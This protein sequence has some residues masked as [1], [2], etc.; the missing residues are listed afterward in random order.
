MG[1]GGGGGGGG[2]EK[3]VKD[4]WEDGWMDGW[5]VCRERERDLVPYFPVTPT[6][7]YH[8]SD[9]AMGSEEG[10]EGVDGGLTLRAL[11]HGC[12]LCGWIGKVRCAGV[13][14]FSLCKNR[15]GADSP[16]LPDQC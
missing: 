11:R 6:S 8:V 1:G 7:G 3:V 14:V 10:R 4:R 2:E 16:K 12:G 9:L 13:D 15:G 5:E